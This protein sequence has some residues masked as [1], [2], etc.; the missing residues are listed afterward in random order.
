MERKQ[1]AS[2][3]REE[4]HLEKSSSSKPPSRKNS[5]SEGFKNDKEKSGRSSINE[6]LGLVVIDPLILI[7]QEVVQI[8]REMDRIVGEFQLI[9]RA[10]QEETGQKH[11]NADQH[12]LVLRVKFRWFCLILFSIFAIYFFVFFFEFFVFFVEFFEFF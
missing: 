9:L 4:K 12:A 2:E 8:R 6:G 1:S 11:T 3:M 5:E 7:K 10:F